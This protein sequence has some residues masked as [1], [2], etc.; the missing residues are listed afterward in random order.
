MLELSKEQKIALVEREVV[1]HKQEAFVLTIKGRCAG[2]LGNTKNVDEIQKML[3][4]NTKAIAFYEEEIE[5]MKQQ[6][7]K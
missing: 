7:P 4:S 3:E 5:K 6:P 2:V 1:M